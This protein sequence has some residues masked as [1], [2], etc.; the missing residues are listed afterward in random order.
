MYLVFANIDILEGYKNIID[1]FG[2]RAYTILACLLFLTSS[3]SAKTKVTYS[4]DSIGSYKQ[5]AVHYAKQNNA[6][7][8]IHYIVQYIGA[9][10]DM[11]FLNDHVFDN[12]KD[13]SKYVE[14]KQQYEPKFNWL[15]LLY[16]YA[17]FLGFYMFIMLNLR[18]DSDRISSL[19]IS[20]FVLFHS[21]FIL[22]L[23]LYVV[24]YQYN[25]PHTLFISTTFSFLY[26][27]L[28][29]F[30]LKRSMTSYKFRWRDLLHLVP[31]VVLFIYILPYYLMSGAEK[32]QV[33][34][35]QS[36]FLLPGAQAIIIVKILVLAFYAF[37]ILGIYKKQK[38]AKIN[39]FSNVKNWYRNVI[40]I[41]MAYIVVYIAYALTIT[42][43]FVVPWFF[44]L[45]IIVMVSLVFYVA[46]MAYLKPDVFR[47][48]IKVIDP[49]S[50]LKYKKSGLTSSYSIELKDKL[51]ELLE[52]DKIYRENDI[53]LQKL[54]ERLGTTRH[55]TSQ[56]VNEHFNLNF[57]ELINK[58]RIEEALELLR[59]DRNKNLNIIDIAYQVGFNNKVTFN[60]SFKKYLSQT[61]SQ[62]LATLPA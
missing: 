8:A 28:L 36:N 40:G 51:L 57:F 50:L 10:S 7:K 3:I 25:L 13:S 52:I 12:I 15:S 34:F 49:A 46:Y 1:R 29:Y 18:K 62:F 26:G 22:H 45:Q 60:K 4:K 53:N 30:Y 32:F 2:I 17:G 35:D 6:E 41:Y 54:S 5:S 61:P 44:D 58:Y 20:L 39:D 24:N 37:L 38:S 31:T 43:I 27:P 56:I 33:I 55:N 23:S 11:S 9:S 14:L 19:L 21:L 47:G 48:T 42:E 59:S 16:F